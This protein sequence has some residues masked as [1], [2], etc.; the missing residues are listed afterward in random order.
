MGVAGAFGLVG[1]LLLA[2]CEP[3]PPNPPPPGPVLH[4]KPVEGPCTYRDTYGAPRSGGRV[5][6]GVDIS[7]AE[8]NDLFAVADGTITKVYVAG[9]DAL[10]GNG[11]RIT[12]PDGHYFFYAHMQ[13]VASGIQV[14]S[15]VTAG[16]LVGY[17]GQT[18]NAGGPHLHLEV[19]LPNG[20]PINPYPLVKYYGA[21]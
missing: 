8:G 19:H 18:G 7:A 12:Q 9:V 2:D 4:A 1:A 21:C 10:A 15:R 14:G 16:Q 17:L 11:V 6:L 13:R 5:H 20:S 3:P